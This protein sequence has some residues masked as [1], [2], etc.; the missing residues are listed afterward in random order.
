M[1]LVQFDFAGCCSWILFGALAGWIASLITRRNR[2]GCITNIVVGID[3]AV[4]R[5]C[6]GTRAG[7]HHRA[8]FTSHSMAA[9]LEPTPCGTAAVLMVL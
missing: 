4:G 7:Q 5:S 6:G 3:R 2:Q 9:Q 1:D 8:Q